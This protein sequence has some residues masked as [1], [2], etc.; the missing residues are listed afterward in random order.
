MDTNSELVECVEIRQKNGV[1]LIEWK[2]GAGLRRAWVRGD[3]IVAR[4]GKKVRVTLPNGGV[5]YGVDWS[6]LIGNI[7]IAADDLCAELRRNGIWT[8]EDLRA[9]PNAALSAIQGASGVTLGLL[10]NAAKE[11]DRSTGA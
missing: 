9:N 10:I 7:T 6:K 4:E 2:Q 3:Q 8:T 11:Y 1:H 5:P